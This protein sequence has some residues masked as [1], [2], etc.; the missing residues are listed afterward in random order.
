MLLSI[1]QICGLADR[2]GVYWWLGEARWLSG[3]EAI[4]LRSEPGYY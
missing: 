4:G 2:A 1:A 3:V